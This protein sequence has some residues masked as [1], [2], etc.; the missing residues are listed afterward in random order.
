M[1]LDLIADVIDSK[2]VQDERIIWRLP[3]IPF[4]F[5]LGRLVSGAFRSGCSDF[6]NHRYLTFGTKPD[7]TSFWY[8]TWRD[9]NGY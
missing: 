4:Y 2:M 8:W 7:T 1:Y 5:D 9:Y 6:S 3:G